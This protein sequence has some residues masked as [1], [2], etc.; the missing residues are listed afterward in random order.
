M[1][2]AF[3][4]VGLVISLACS[5]QAQQTAVPQAGQDAA[6]RIGDRTVTLRELDDR[7]KIEDPGQKAQAE[8]ALFDGRKAALDAIVAEMLV[9]EAAKAKN[10]TPEAFVQAE[11]GKRVKPVTDA[12]VRTFYVQNSERMQGRSFEQMNPA[13]HKYLEEQQQT[14]ARQSLIDE[15]RK[16]GPPIRVLMDAPRTSVA[17]TGDDPS[18]GS[19]TAPVT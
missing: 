1:R 6:A 2:I 9:A 10:L 19:A 12:D 15:L 11:V 13:I 17:V 16:A 5:S 18:E 4:A 7:W 8:Q 3:I 14:T